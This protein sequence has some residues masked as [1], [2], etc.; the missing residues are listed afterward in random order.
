MIVLLRMIAV[1]LIGF[2]AMAVLAWGWVWWLPYAMQVGDQ[3]GPIWRSV[4]FAGMGAVSIAIAWALY[5]AND[6]LTR[7]LDFRIHGRG[8]RDRLFC[9]RCGTPAP[10]GHVLCAVCGGTRF[11]LTRP[12]SELPP[13]S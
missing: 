6:R 5:G 12:V 9:Q 11:G 3:H 4:A 2:T 1:L 10:A 7:L 8:V 13:T